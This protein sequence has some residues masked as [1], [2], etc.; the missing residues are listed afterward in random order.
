MRKILSLIFGV[1]AI[2]SA[3]GLLILYLWIGQSIKDHIATTQ[4][5]YPGTAEDALISFLLDETN[6]TVDRTH[7]AVWTLGQIKSEKA[8]PIL[9]D[10]YRDDPKG[11]TCYGRHDTLLC[12]YEIYKAIC[13]IEKRTLFSFTRFK[14]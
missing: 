10:L 6:S 11:N 8:L 3:G 4:Q 2:L 1:I 14:Q 5:K 12:Q 13:T 7:V 9:K